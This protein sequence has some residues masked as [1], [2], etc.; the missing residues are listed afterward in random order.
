[1][2]YPKDLKKLLPPATSTPIRA[3]N[4]VSKLRRIRHEVAILMQQLDD[5]L[6]ALD[7]P[8]GETA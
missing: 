5:T 2:A 8:K 3:A 1:M 7:D 4:A 6:A